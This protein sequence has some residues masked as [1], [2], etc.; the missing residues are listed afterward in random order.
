[1]NRV[2]TIK[3]LKKE[4]FHI[5]IPLMKDCFGMDVNIEYFLWK[6]QHNPAGFV[7]GFYAVSQCGEIAAYYGV[8]PELYYYHERE[9]IIYQSCDTMT[10]SKHRRQGLFE[11]LSRHCY[12]YLRK[13]KKLFVIGFGG[14]ESTPGLLKFGWTFVFNIK[15]YFKTVY[16]C[17]L[18]NRCLPFKKLNLN[19][20]SREEVSVNDIIILN[21]H[22]QK[23]TISKVTDQTVLEWKL[24]NPL[25]DF[26]KIGIYNLQNEMV[27]YCVYFSHNNKVF[28]YDFGFSKNCNKSLKKML[29]RKLDEIV[30]NN[31]LKGIVTFAQN[32]TCFSKELKNLGFIS[33]PFKFGP[34]CA[35]IPFL[36]YADNNKF[37]KYENSD[38]WSVTPIYHDSL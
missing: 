1:M 20:T 17:Y 23:N 38:F 16:Q 29:F 32:K 25:Y 4:D 6:F 21:E 10:H 9:T 24:S 34:L 8:I 27:A 36:V 37:E 19:Y 12:D 7:E 2:Y 35:N 11:K 5:L 26:K 31:K 15:F 22:K 18:Q 13:E 14:K 3:K 28:L 30:I 33:N